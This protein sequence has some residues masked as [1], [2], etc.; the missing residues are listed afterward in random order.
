MNKKEIN[1]NGII[2]NSSE[3]SIDKMK[4]RA[5]TVLSPEQV[6]ELTHINDAEKISVNDMVFIDRN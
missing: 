1:K 6:D 2:I 5:G 3:D 4:Y